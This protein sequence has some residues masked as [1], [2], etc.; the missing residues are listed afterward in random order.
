MVNLNG[1]KE[2][3]SLDFVEK[4]K[5]FYAFYI[6]YFD[7]EK[8]IVYVFRIYFKNGLLGFFQFFRRIILFL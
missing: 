6:E 7:Y 5:R 2:F 3:F 8:I 4:F 1:V